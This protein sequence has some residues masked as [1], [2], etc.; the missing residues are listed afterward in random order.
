MAKPSKDGR[1]A[2]GGV[3]GER[4]SGMDQ[5]ADKGE[6]VDREGGDASKGSAGDGIG[7]AP[8]GQDKQRDFIGPIEAAKEGVGFSLPADV[9]QASAKIAGEN[10]EEHEEVHVEARYDD[11]LGA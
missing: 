10:D 3:D 5:G 6:P 8:A 7:S 2:E 4:R 1:R 9:D 11:L